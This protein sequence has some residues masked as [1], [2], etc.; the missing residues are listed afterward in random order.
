MGFC[1]AQTGFLDKAIFC[2]EKFYFKE[3]SVQDLLKAARFYTLAGRYDKAVELY[4][5]IVE[6]FPDTVYAE[7]SKSLINLLSQMEEPYE[8]EQVSSSHTE[9]GSFPR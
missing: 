3:G 2:E 5:R 8:N 7:Y 1:L 4:K 6:Y 9:G